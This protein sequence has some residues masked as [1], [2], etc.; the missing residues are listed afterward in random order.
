MY[1]LINYGDVES[2]IEEMSAI[3]DNKKRHFD[4]NNFILKGDIKVKAID[5]NDFEF[6]FFA[7][8]GI[9]KGLYYFLIYNK[10]TKEML[11]I[12]KFSVE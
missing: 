12:S 4:N 7:N 1:R 6:V 3:Y 5:D 11:T 2:I 8:T 10:E 9:T